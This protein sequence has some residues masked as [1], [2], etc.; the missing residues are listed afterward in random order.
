MNYCQ[1][2]LQVYFATETQQY[3]Y[4]PIYGHYKLQPNDVNGRPYF[5]MGTYGLWWNGNGNWWIGF[6]SMKGQSYGFAY[7]TRDV[8]CPH[9]IE[10]NWIVDDG[11]DWTAA[12]SDLCITCKCLILDG[13]QKKISLWH[14]Y[15]VYFCLPI[16]SS[17][18]VF[19]YYVCG[20]HKSNF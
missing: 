14:S 20:I 12:H 4:V 15:M 5:K 19:L 18:I 7:F 13:E 16:T 11:S 6:D 17:I 9:E 2:G 8:F 10:C 3:T 1:D